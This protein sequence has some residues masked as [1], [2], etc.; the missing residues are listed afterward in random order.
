MARTT[1]L[2]PPTFLLALKALSF[3][4]FA[5]VTKW[6]RVIAAVFRADTGGIKGRF[7]YM[8]LVFFGA[9]LA[10][11]SREGEWRH[12]HVHSCADSANIALFAHLLSGVT[13]SLTLHGQLSFFGPNQREKWK[14]AAFSIAVSDSLVREVRHQSWGHLPRIVKKAPMGVDTHIFRRNAPYVPWKPGEICRVFSCGRLNP[15]KRHKDIV[16]AVHLLKSRGIG[17]ELRIAGEDDSPDGRIRNSLEQQVERLALEKHVKLI[18]AVSE[19]QV[20]HELEHAHIFVLASRE[21]ALGVATMEAMSMGVPVVATDVGG[22]P[23]LV[24]NGET[25]LLVPPGKPRDIARAMETILSNS[26]LARSF[27]SA[28]RKK[29]ELSFHERKSAETIMYALRESGVMP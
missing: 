18:G 6:R 1:Y 10:H 23:E 24:E 22:V 17:I 11:R 27:S 12:V 25:G 16:E 26:D 8:A 9:I 14:H 21:E 4:L 13:Y 29:I 19:E 20:C 28:S 7:R 3:F 5:G 2:F 15:G